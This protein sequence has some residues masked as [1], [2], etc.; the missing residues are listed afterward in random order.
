M[1]IAENK[2]RNTNSK[3]GKQKR[4]QGDAGLREDFIYKMDNRLD[5]IL[6]CAEGTNQDEVS[7]LGKRKGTTDAIK[8]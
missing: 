6:F 3:L 7:N 5:Q 4:A 2:W 8:S 1:E